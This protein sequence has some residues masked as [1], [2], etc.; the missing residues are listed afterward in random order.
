MGI[1]AD[2]CFER[3]VTRSFPASRSGRAVS[4]GTQ[5][6]QDSPVRPNAHRAEAD[7]EIGESD[8]EQT[9]PRPAHVLAVKA[10][11]AIIRLGDRRRPRQQVPAS[12]DQMPQGVAAECVTREQ[13]DVR[14]QHNAAHTYTELD[15][16]S[17]RLQEP[18]RLPSVIGQHNDKSKRQIEEIAVHILDDKRKRALAAIPRSRFSNGA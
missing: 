14:E 10:A 13:R 1:R 16:A 8:R 18:E 7:V 15:R 4:A 3:P 9:H 17:C 2:R 6:L 11:H 5:S 12:S